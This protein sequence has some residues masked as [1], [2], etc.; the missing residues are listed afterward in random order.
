MAPSII[1]VDT[2]YVDDKTV[3][4]LAKYNLDLVYDP[5]SRK[6]EPQERVSKPI[7]M[8]VR[9]TCHRCNTTFG[10]ERECIS[11]QHRRCSRCTRYPPKKAKKKQAAAPG[12]PEDAAQPSMAPDRQCACHMC[13]TDILQETQECPNC[14]HKICD[15]CLK[16]AQ[17]EIAQPTTEVTDVAERPK[18][19]GEEPEHTAHSTSEPTAS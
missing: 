5:P 2:D 11:C 7:K 14:H 12:A 8:R 1:E 18:P 6:V 19:A 15:Q 10:H 16:E 17:L 4:L 13:Q 3:K 9:F